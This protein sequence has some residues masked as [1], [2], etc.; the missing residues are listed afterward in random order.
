DVDLFRP[1]LRLGVDVEA[2]RKYYQP[3]DGVFGS[4]RYLCLVE[5]FT[6][7]ELHKTIF[8]VSLQ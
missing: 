7:M 2:H 4:G 8:E 3:V 5:H 6:M 1:D